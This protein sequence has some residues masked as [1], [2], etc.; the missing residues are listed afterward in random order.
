MSFP[1]KTKTVNIPFNW[2]DNWRSNEER[3]VRSVDQNMFNEAQPV[4][5][6]KNGSIRRDNQLG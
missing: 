4:S 5:S 3:G 6:Q 2:H 1:K